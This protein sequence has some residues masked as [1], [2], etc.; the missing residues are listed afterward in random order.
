MKEFDLI[1]RFFKNKGHQ[2]K[3]VVIGVGDDCAVMTVPNNQQLAVTTDTLVEGVHFLADTPAR[4]VA[5]KAV[6]VNLSD[7]AAMGAEPSWV[8]M[9]LSV[10]SIDE[11]WMQAFADGFYQLLEYYD[12]QLVGGDTV[13][14]PLS[15]TLTAH[16]FIPPENQITR[17]GAKSGDWVYVTGTLGDA[18]AGLALLQSDVDIRGEQHQYLVNRHLYPTPRVMAGT[19]LRRIANACIDVSDGL[20]ADI[21]HIQ[22]LSN[23]GARLFIEKLPLS[24]QL[25]DI[26]GMDEARSLALGAGDDYE[27]LFTVSE[28]QKGLLETILT[29]ANLTATCIGQVT[30][31]TGKTELLLD[32][33]PYQPP[34]NMG[35]E[36]FSG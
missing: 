17:S 6:A 21:R 7:L 14:G 8:S 23:V 35:F 30:G 9:S 13:N 32:N 24:N 15:I 25:V 31:H 18:G 3:D 27:L 29:S 33:S 16:G 12:V 1:E 34:E 2:R 20:M 10:P 22:T 4:S 19:V 36:H 11:D 28:E 5:Y 26:F